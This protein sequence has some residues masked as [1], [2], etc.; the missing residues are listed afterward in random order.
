M[1]GVRDVKMLGRSGF[2]DYDT[3]RRPENVVHREPYMLV[4]AKTGDFAEMV[5]QGFWWGLCL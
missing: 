5:N 4:R 2:D 3:I 1:R